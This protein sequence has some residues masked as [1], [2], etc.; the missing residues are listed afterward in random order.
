ML[1]ILV[2]VCY[3]YNLS[4]YIHIHTYV[5]HVCHQDL[6]HGECHTVEVAHSSAT[7]LGDN[8]T[9]SHICTY[10]HM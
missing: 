2:N 1:I 3:V 8:S 6:G 9:H 4:T 5:P 7:D 10:V